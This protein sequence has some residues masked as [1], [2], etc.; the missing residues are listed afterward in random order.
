MNIRNK[1]S[2]AVLCE[3][4][5]FAKSYWQKTKGLMFRKSLSPRKGLLMVFERPTRV[6]IWMFGMRFPIDVVFID[7]KKR[8][9]SVRRN[10][11]PMSI[12]LKTWRVYYPPKSAKYILE[13]NKGQAAKTKKGDILVF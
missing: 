9:I 11:K 2:N 10:L 13:L 5:E 3:R 6:G 1:T 7:A 4:T 8:V 12:N